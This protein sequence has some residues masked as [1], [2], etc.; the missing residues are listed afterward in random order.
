MDNS[1]KVAFR[2]SIGG[3]NRE[4]VHQY[5]LKADSA[6]AEREQSLR[7]EAETARR[8][9]DAAAA[10][11]QSE[12]EKAARLESD[13]V[14]LKE[15]LAAVQGELDAAR[16]ELESAAER[17]KDDAARIASLEEQLQKRDTQSAEETEQKS[18]KYDRISAQIGDIMINA[19]TTADSIIATA[20]R[21]AANIVTETEEEAVAIRSHL[22]QTT[23]EALERL[24]TVLHAST[25]RC[26]GEM[27]GMLSQMREQAD[28]LIGDFSSQTSTLESKIAEHQSAVTEA[29]DSA[30]NELDEKY[31]IRPEK[32]EQPE[33]SDKKEDNP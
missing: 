31:G 27:I 5:I 3:Y 23:D 17:Q 15:R 20:T 29:L 14:Q 11:A 16:K 26:V 13:L 32:A 2:S 33:K 24:S 22:S 28:L 25:D 4:D 1:K 18:K 9:A 7:E 30:L 6:A 21:R 12:R 10:E 19:N 8:S